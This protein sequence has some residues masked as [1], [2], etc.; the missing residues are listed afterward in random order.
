MFDNIKKF[1]N[2]MPNDYIKRQLKENKIRYILGCIIIYSIMFAWM[3]WYS[4][5]P[6]NENC[7]NP[8]NCNSMTIQSN[9]KQGCCE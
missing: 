4:N 6:P 5:T 3:Q 8:S 1:W 7:C 2:E 9:L